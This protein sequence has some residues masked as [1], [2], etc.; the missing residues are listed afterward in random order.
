MKVAN[1]MEEQQRKT[2]ES[3]KG[4]VERM[5]DM[6]DEYDKNRTAKTLAQKQELLAKLAKAESDF[7]GLS[8][9]VQFSEALNVKETEE[10]DSCR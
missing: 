9:S 10:D 6:M 8:G 5:R 7:S 2:E 3:A 1:L 4:M